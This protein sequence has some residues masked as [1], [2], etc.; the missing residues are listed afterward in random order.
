M[1]SDTTAINKGHLDQERQN[2]QSTKITEPKEE[3]QDAFPTNGVGEKTYKYI[4]G[5]APLN[6]KMKVFLDLM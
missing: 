4:L 1:I 3:I 2:L 6:S 5:G